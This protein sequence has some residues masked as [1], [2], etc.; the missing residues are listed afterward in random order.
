MILR[1]QGIHPFNPRASTAAPWDVT[2]QHDVLVHHQH[3]LAVL[4]RRDDDDLLLADGRAGRA[5]LRL[6]RGR[7]GGARRGDP[8][9]RAAAARTSSAT[10]GGTS[11]GRCSTSC[12]R[13]RSSARCPRLPGR[14]PDAQRLRVASRR[15]SAAR[16]DPRA[17]PGGLADRDQA[18]RHQRRRLLQR[19]QRD[20]VREPDRVLELRRG[21][22]HPADPGGADRAPSAAWSA[23]AARAGRCTRR[24]CDVLVGGDRGRLRRRAAR[25]AGAARGRHRRWPR[26]TAPRAA[27]WRARSSASGSP[28]A[29]LWATATTDA[30]NGSVNSAH[31]AYT[32]IG[33][34][35]AARQHD[36]RRGDLRRGRLG[37]LRDAAVR[38]AGRVHRRADGRAH[39]GVP[40]QED[41]GARGEA[42]R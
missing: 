4:R 20:A 14:D 19:Q 23:T 7:H 26:P 29:P 24:C 28:T 40:R 8:R 10:S 22:L 9:L 41:R 11:P 16:P 36:D 37:P 25:L 2:L 35:R 27:T 42:G 38:P 18:A 21:A 5:E 31:D 3:E 12:C 32:G 30:S 1:T 17:R 34:A 13:C 6:G 15:R 39:A 33:G